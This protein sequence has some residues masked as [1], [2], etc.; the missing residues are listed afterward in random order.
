MSVFN[1]SAVSGICL[2]RLLSYTYMHKG[3]KKI[4]LSNKIEFGYYFEYE[5]FRSLLSSSG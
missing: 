2:G 3:K 4:K 5:R 1:S